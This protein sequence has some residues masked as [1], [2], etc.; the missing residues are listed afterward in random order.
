MFRDAHR[1][2]KVEEHRVLVVVSDVDRQVSHVLQQAIRHGH[3]D[4]EFIHVLVIKVSRG[5]AEYLT[6]KRRNRSCQQLI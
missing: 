5:T 3:Q 6:F 2:R 1:V 4:D